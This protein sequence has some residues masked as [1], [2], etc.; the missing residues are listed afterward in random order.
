MVMV[1]RLVWEPVVVGAGSV[2]KVA[3]TAVAV[4]SIVAYT[5]KGMR[6]PASAVR[7]PTMGPAMFPMRKAAPRAEEQRPRILAG[8]RRTMRAE[9][10]TTNMAEPIPPRVR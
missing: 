4:R 8:A 1:G 3:T 5:M 10:D 6:Y 7:P 9:E 2:R